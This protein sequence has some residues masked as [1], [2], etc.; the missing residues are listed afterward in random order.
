M[1]Y[2]LGN[3][4][5]KLRLPNS[6][7]TLPL[8]DSAD[9]L[10]M[11]QDQSRPFFQ[12]HAGFEL[13]H[14]CPEPILSVKDHHYYND[15]FWQWFSWTR[16]CDVNCKQTLNSRTAPM[17]LARIQHKKLNPGVNLVAVS[18]SHSMVARVSSRD[19]AFGEIFWPHSGTP[20][21]T[22]GTPPVRSTEEM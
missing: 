5:R 20:C 3:F 6:G 21:F 22:C 9:G 18:R 13:P 8:T 15:N 12:F 14:W 11:C 16:H 10:S 17:P 1:F 7:Y 19:R 4:P 2:S